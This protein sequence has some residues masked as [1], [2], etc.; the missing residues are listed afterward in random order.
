MTVRSV[1]ACGQSAALSKAVSLLA[2]MVDDGYSPSAETKGVFEIYPNPTTGVFVI[3][4]SH[5]GEFEILNGMGQ[6]LDKFSV[7]NE[8]TFVKELHLSTT[9]MYFIR[10]VSDGS[11]QRIVVVN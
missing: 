9:G 1:N 4:T 8:Q 10:A 6:L 11:I 3:R 7:G 5:A 2:C